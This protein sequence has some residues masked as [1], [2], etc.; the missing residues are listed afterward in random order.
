MSEST[1]GLLDLL[2]IDQRQRWQR[3]ER[4]LAESYLRQ[5]PA[6]AESPDAYLDLIY[7]E[8][9]LRERR[10]E[11]PLVDEYVQRFPQLAGPLRTQFEVHQ[12]LNPGELFA[13]A[14]EAVPQTQLTGCGSAAPAK[15]QATT[16][17]PV[18]FPSIPGFEILGELGRGATGVV[19]QARQTSLKRIVALKMIGNGAHAS[20]KEL[21]RFGAEAEAVA[22]LQHPNIV[23]IYAIGEHEGR[24]YFALELVEGGSLARWLTGNRPAPRDA[25]RIIEILARAIHFAH[26]HGIVHRDLKPANILVKGGMLSQGKATINSALV[27]HQLKITDFGLA[28]RLD[29]DT[30]LTRLGD[31]L[32]TPNYMPAEQARGQVGKVGPAADIYALGAI[33]YEM[34]TG[35]PPV[36]GKTV[37]DTLLEVERARPVPPSQIQSKVPRDLEAICLKCLEKKP[38]QRYAS[39]EALADD[40]RHFVQGETIVARPVS[41]GERGLKWAR[42]RP[43]FAALLLVSVVGLLALLVGNWVYTAQVQKERNN[44]I[45]GWKLADQ[46]R[47]ELKAAQGELEAQ[48]DA[49]AKAKRDAEAQ[50]DAARQ[51]KL[52]AEAQRDAAAKA[53]EQAEKRQAEAVRS[54]EDARRSSY[55]LQLTRVAGLWQHDPARGLELLEDR[56]RCPP[57]LRD[58]TWGLLHHSCQREQRTLS[59][60]KGPVLAVQPSPDGKLLASAGSDHSVRLWDLETG[61]LLHTLTGHTDKVTGVAFTS[62]SKTLVSVSA[63]QTAL[64]WDVAGGKQLRSLAAGKTPILC[65]AFA[66]GTTVAAFGCGDGNVRLWEVTGTKSDRLID[67]T[68]KMK[69]AH[70]DTVNALA[71][72]PDGKTLASVSDDRTLKLW[73]VNTGKARFTSRAFSLQLH[74]VAFSPDS[75]AVAT[76]GADGSVKLWNATVG[77]VRLNLP[78]HRGAVAGLAFSPD[79]KLLA[80]AAALRDKGGEVKLWDPAGGQSLTGLPHPAGEVNAVAFL[81]GRSVLA[82]ASKM[83]EVE[84]WEAH[85]VQERLALKKHAGPVLGLAFS[86]DNRTLATAGVDKLVKL[87]DRKTGDVRLT[88]TGHTDEVTALAFAPGSRLL[89]SG[90]ADKTVKLWNTGTGRLVNTLEGHR[91]R[92]TAV[93]VSADRDTV[94][95]ACADGVIKLWRQGKELFELRGHIDAVTALAFSPD[96]KVLVSAG[97]DGT[98]RRWQ[99]ADGTPR[100]IWM[101]HDDA[102]LA[103]AFS[104]DGGTLAS[105]SSD[106]SIRFWEVSSGKVVLTLDGHRGGVRCLS[107]SPDGRTLASGAGPGDP[108]EGQVPGEVKLWDTM[109]GQERASLR[110]H[111]LGVLALAFAADG[112]TLATSSQDDT[113]M[114]WEADGR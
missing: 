10:G 45:E 66:P 28:K 64:S 77:G 35:R 20:S 50:R 94:A 48:R 80:S 27:A 46:Q 71:F 13:A 6:L 57:D 95:S 93:A 47:S 74:A 25:A 83:P 42:R 31:V 69:K 112:K 109:A 81:P 15:P 105:G 114:L 33:L 40:L 53:R 2:L 92:I 97:K 101:A 100:A 1:Q 87:L 90:S 86:P 55:A 67:A 51:A 9:V 107:F 91:D 19:Y 37:F 41:L 78:A 8:V 111:V 73:D 5:H 113:V 70:R 72:S 26:Q 110:G 68:L 103:V 44:A 21:A 108:G 22:R 61:K 62:D 65:V 102:V 79:G 29:G 98:V 75:K 4:V 106:G 24:P 89:A 104:P 30:R 32:G 7:H 38:D 16:S 59:G 82:I 17:D 60:H 39:A 88:L 34:L 12:G 54:L 36:Q 52:E 43:S 18:A 23:Q 63:D 3:G 56:E 99:P 85:L 76:G 96:G 84:L 11:Q 58:F 14:G 49:A